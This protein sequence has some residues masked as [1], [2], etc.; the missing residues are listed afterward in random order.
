MQTERVG[1]ITPMQQAFLMAAGRDGV[2]ASKVVRQV[3][4]V[5][6]HSRPQ[7]VRSVSANLSFKTAQKLTKEGVL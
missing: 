5:L 2:G 1:F 4:R 6:D 3:A 7:L